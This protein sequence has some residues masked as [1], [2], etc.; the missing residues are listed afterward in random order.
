MVRRKCMNFCLI[1]GQIRESEFPLRWKLLPSR[2]VPGIS[3]VPQSLPHSPK[4]S[5]LAD[6]NSSKSPLSVQWTQDVKLFHPFS[7]SRTTA[8]R[9]TTHSFVWKLSISKWQKMYLY[10]NIKIL[11]HQKPYDFYG[12]LSKWT[13]I[14]I[15]N[16]HFSRTI[17]STFVQW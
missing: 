17:S 3:D 6:T 8:S 10:N 13:V 1:E 7:V 4:L 14:S 15:N 12:E 16:S 9:A 11:E 2:E 5:V